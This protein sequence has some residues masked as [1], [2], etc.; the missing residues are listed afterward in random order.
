MCRS[1]T[2]KEGQGREG[3]FYAPPFP[4]DRRQELDNP[5]SKQREIKTTNSSTLITDR[6]STV[7]ESNKTK[8]SQMKSKFHFLFTRLAVFAK[9]KGTEPD[10][11]DLTQFVYYGAT[12]NS[13]TLI[14]DRASRVTAS[15]KTKESQ[16]KSRFHKASRCSLRLKARNQAL[17]TRLFSVEK[18][19]TDLRRR[20]LRYLQNRSFL[21]SKT[22]EHN[23]YTMEP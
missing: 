6:S 11:C 18:I 23:L 13:S 17:V 1:G 8:E 9:I 2:S 20:Y 4:L 10:T 12:T 15:N 19:R 14:T 3:P 5:R 16:I 21:P 22:A 7:T